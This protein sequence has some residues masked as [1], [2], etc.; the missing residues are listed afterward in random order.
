[1]IK[2]EYNGNTYRRFT[3]AWVDDRNIEVHA[4]LQNCLNRLYAES[5][6]LSA[7][8]VR[9]LIGEGDKFKASGSF[10]LAVKYYETAAE[11]CE[12]AELRYI[13]PRLSSCHRRCNQPQK[14]IELFSYAKQKFGPE[15]ITPVL[16]TTAAA[17][18]CDLLDYDRAL[19]CCRRAWAELGGEWN[20][21]LQ[22]VFE[23]I[24]KAT[25][26]SKK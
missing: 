26:E 25:G 12:E 13:L 10:L 17:A 11:Q 3:D 16:L 9:E 14:A 4:T 20:P 15:M 5:L 7:F 19:Q 2:L 21:N 22:S 1:M 18:Y 24:R 8:G 6:D 23:R